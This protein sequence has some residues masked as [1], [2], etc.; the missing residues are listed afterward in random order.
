LSKWNL[1]QWDF[2]TKEKVLP[3]IY[4]LGILRKCLVHKYMPTKAVVAL[5]F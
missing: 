3:A 4:Y 5:G 1:N 2:D